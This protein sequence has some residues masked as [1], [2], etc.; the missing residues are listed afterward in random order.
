VAT[1]DG[2]QLRALRVLRYWFG[3]LEV[4]QVLGGQVTPKRNP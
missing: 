2:D 1:L 3:D 4:L